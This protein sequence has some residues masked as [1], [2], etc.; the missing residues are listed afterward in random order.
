MR[1]AEDVLDHIG[2]LY[3]ELARV[4]KDLTD[5]A[6]WRKSV[7]ENLDYLVS[8]I[9]DGRA[10]DRIVRND[11]IMAAVE[12]IKSLREEVRRAAKITSDKRNSN[13][14]PNSEP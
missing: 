6:A 13:K 4:G 5:A 10:E 14:P 9:L 3:S 7:N 12:M 11:P 2:N 1:N 8:V